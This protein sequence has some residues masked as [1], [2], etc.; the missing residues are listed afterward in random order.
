MHIVPVYAIIKPHWNSSSCADVRGLCE[1]RNQFLCKQVCSFNGEDGVY[2]KKRI[3]ASLLALCLMGGMLP[4]AAL[5][6][7]PDITMPTTERKL[8]KNN[9]A[10]ANRAPLLLHLQEQREISQNHYWFV[11][12]KKI[13]LPVALAEKI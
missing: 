6:S 10:P 1:I 12:G 13:L 4:T 5:A 11:R 9:G 2:M 8:E 3:L 7:E